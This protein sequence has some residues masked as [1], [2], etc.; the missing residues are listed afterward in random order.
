MEDGFAS[1]GCNEVRTLKAGEVI[2]VLEGPRK[3]EV[4][5]TLR[6]RAKALSDGATGWF[7]LKSKHGQDF[8]EPGKI[9]YTTTASIALTDV[10]DLKECSVIRKLDKGEVLMVL[11]G[12]V[13]DESQ[14]SAGNVSR[15]KVRAVKGGSEG[16]VTVKGNAGTVFAEESGQQHVVTK[17]TALQ[18]DVK[19]D[20][21]LNMRMLV[22]QELVQILEGPKEQK[23]EPAVRVRGCSLT[24]GKIG[25]STLR[26][27]NLKQWSSNYRCASATQLDNGPDSNQAGAVRALAVGESLQLLE[28]PREVTGM[29]RIKVRAENDEAVGW[30]S[31]TGAGGKPVFV[32]CIPA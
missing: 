6:V 19:I 11:E 14:G 10:L 4:S 12:P 21:S 23:S 24:D 20:T 25:W 17:A 3:E 31:I 22:E 16:W 28:G 29:L 7:T 2:E 15:I 9:T 5:V 8:A 13:D 1:E 27:G 18:T 26:N 30:V 32:E